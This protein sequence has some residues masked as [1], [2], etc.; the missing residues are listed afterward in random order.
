MH[1][2]QRDR[3]ILRVL[4]E[5]DVVSVHVLTEELGI[6]EATIRRDLKRLSDA[7]RLHRV[8]GGARSIER[9]T[10]VGQPLFGPDREQNAEAKRA[11]ARLAVSLCDPGDAVI[12]DGGTTVFAMTDFL[13]KLG[14]QVL[15]PSLPVAQ[16]L[17]TTANARI[18][19][20]GGEFFREQQ[21]IAS[22]YTQP[23]VRSFSA[24][25]MFLSAQAV[26]SHGLLQTDSLLVRSQ[27]E[28]IDR[29]EE[30]VALVD[31]SKFER[32][33]NLVSCPLSDIDVLISDTGLSLRHRKLLMDAGVRVLIAD[34]DKA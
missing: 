33:G 8:R 11:I 10:L 1:E 20:P 29:A 32:R 3:A 21:I 31:S 22:P 7:G 16:A 23:M 14:L 15:T 4:A 9:P 12:L 18:L 24:R 30:L 34:P 5:N 6:S 17:S 13:A 28:M 25:R 2:T 26:S 19:V 27:L